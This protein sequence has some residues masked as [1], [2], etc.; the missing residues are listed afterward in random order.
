MLRNKRL[1]SD[2]LGEE[3]RV[4][5]QE[6]LGLTKGDFAVLLGIAE[7]LKPKFYVTL[8]GD[9]FVIQEVCDLEVSESVVTRASST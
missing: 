9:P 2:E 1:P 4:R 6:V 3:V 8:V 7:K 5:V